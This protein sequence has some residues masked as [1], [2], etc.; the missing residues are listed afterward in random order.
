MG[1]VEN[2]T[3]SRVGGG[4]E[5]DRVATTKKLIWTCYPLPN[6]DLLPL[7]ELDSA[8][9]SEFDKTDSCTTKH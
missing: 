7:E 8:K 1:I 5:M 6:L 2:S 9:S 4:S 3:H